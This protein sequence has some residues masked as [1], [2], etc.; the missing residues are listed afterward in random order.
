MTKD[1]FISALIECGYTVKGAAVLWLELPK[2]GINPATADPAIIRMTAVDFKQN[3]FKL[4]VPADW[5]EEITQPGLCKTCG[6]KDHGNEYCSV[7]TLTGRCGC[8][9]KE[10][11]V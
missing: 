9:L 11:V 7:R 8:K 10:Y 1:E 3:R 6:H 4:N 5:F 2:H